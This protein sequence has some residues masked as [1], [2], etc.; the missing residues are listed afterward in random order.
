[1]PSTVSSVDSTPHFPLGARLGARALQA[2]FPLMSSIPKPLRA[3]AG[4]DIEPSELVVTTRH[5]KVRSLVYAPHPGP[6]HLPVLV[7][8][9]GGAFIV[10]SPAQDAHICRAVAAETRSVVVSVDY[11]TAPAVQYPVAEH[12]AYDVAR[13]VQQNAENQGW[14]ADRLAVGGFSAGA[15]LAINVCQQ[16]R[17]AGTPMPVALVAGYP[18]LDMTL[19]PHDRHSP[20]KHP[21]V[22]PWLI[23][24]MYRSYF[25]VAGERSE[26]LASPGLDDALGALPPT[27]LLTGGDDA[28]AAEEAAFAERLRA[29]GVHLQSHEYPHTDHGFTHNEP[30]ETASD[31][32]ER[33]VAF[34]RTAFATSRPKR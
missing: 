33:I 12:E 2:S 15:K 28:L 34:L 8:L 6:A 31:A 29:A 21:A 17:D 16:A 7:N 4:Y 14:D 27:L 19:G 32:I 13:W 22:A 23:S 25:P 30:A 10:R 18:A 26:P 11:D 3:L 20:A 5:G 24:L 9:H 1:M